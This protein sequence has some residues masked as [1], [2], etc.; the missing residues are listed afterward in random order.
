MELALSLTARELRGNIPGLGK[1]T[2]HRA[3]SEN[4]CTISRAK[5]LSIKAFSFGNR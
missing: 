1:H 4:L 3:A 5:N 2:A